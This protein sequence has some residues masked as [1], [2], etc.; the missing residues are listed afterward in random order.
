MYAAV[1]R[2]EFEKIAR[3]VVPDLAD[4][5][6]DQAT[7][8]YADGDHLLSLALYPGMVWITGMYGGGLLPLWALKKWALKNGYSVVG[9][10][11]K[12]DHPMCQALKRWRGAKAGASYESGTDFWVD[13]SVR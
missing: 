13:L 8:F 2:E 12:D 7:Q 4:A 9:W 11:M 1:S 10:K 3:R 5:F 6:M